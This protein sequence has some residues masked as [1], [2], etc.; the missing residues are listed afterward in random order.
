LA[1]GHG[2]MRAEQCGERPVFKKKK[3]GRPGGA[4]RY[5]A[6]P[7]RYGGGGNY[8]SSSVENSLWWSS[9]AERISSKSFL[10]T[11]SASFAARAMIFL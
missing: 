1:H 8:P 5:A 4:A 7:V 9:S 10:V 2:T 11:M 3:T 6:N